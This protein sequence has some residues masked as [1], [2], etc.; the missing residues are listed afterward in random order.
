MGTLG[1]IRVEL[2]GGLGNQLFQLAAANSLSLE[3]SKPINV[4]ADQILRTHDGTGVLAF[5]L[6]WKV[7][8]RPGLYVRWLRRASRESK[9]GIPPLPLSHVISNTREVISPS[10]LKHKSIQIRGYFEDLPLE[11]CQG[12]MSRL[13]PSPRQ[14]SDWYLRTRRELDLA[15]PIAIH[16]RRGDY[17]LNP[18][19]GVLSEEYYLRAW[20]SLEVKGGPVWVFS[21]DRRSADKLLKKLRLPIERVIPPIAGSPAVESFTLMANARG[22]IGANS[23]LSFWV[24]MYSNQVSVLPS[25]FRPSGSPTPVSRQLPKKV[26]ALDPTWE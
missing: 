6:P 3:F 18:A 11:I 13:T 20:E 10:G 4:Y 1:R 19:W 7:T 14:P 16:I 12:L 8:Q 24:A 9:R 23:T 26:I 15:E 2:L 25:Q 21:D 5:T 22:F 17:L